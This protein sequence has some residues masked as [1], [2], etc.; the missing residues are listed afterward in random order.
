MK[1]Y[2]QE[3]VHSAAYWLR[4]AIRARAN[5]AMYPDYK[6]A[7]E[8]L[9]GMYEQMAERVEGLANPLPNSAGYPLV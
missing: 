8:S 3:S 4:K 2:A 7:L 9:A 1:M 6:D 5:A